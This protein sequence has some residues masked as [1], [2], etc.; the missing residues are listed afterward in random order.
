MP[1]TVMSLSAI[2]ASISAQFF[3]SWQSNKKSKEL[4]ARQREF[5]RAAQEKDFVRMRR[6]QQE[7]EQLA[8]DL[9]NEVHQQ[10]LKDIESNY[11][12]IIEDFAKQF[13]IKLWPLKVLP[14]VM[15][16]E[17][18][19]SIINGTKSVALHCI[20]TPSN[21]NQFNRAVYQD[22]DLRLESLC[23][24]H[25]NAQS[26]HPIVYYG[27]SWRKSELDLD[28]I[29]LLHTQLKNIPT[30]I[31]TPYFSPNLYFKI[32]LWGMGKYY[33]FNI[34][35]PNDKFSYEYKKGMEY[36]PKNEIPVDDLYNSTIDE[37]VPYLE[38]LIGFILDQ[39]YWSFYGIAPMFPSLFKSLDDYR[40]TGLLNNFKDDYI[41]I[42]S[43]EL[44]Q[45]GITYSHNKE[46]ILSLY[47]GIYSIL[48]QKERNVFAK[49]MLSKLASQRGI[50]NLNDHTNLIKC[51]NIKDIEFLQ[52]LRNVIPLKE[53]KNNLLLIINDLNARIPCSYIHLENITFSEIMEYA[54]RLLYDY[55]ELS[56]K[57]EIKKSNIMIALCDI[58][59]GEFIYDSDNPKCIIILYKNL[60]VN[61]RIRI[62]SP[63]IMLSYEDFNTLYNK[64]NKV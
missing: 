6:I 52:K 50:L 1:L 11:D 43:Q 59:T 27:D 22:I 20:L 37:M 23:N 12:E 5:Q 38:S 56:I 62:K 25:W 31:I 13:T 36:F 19:G 61:D 64:I 29:E 40:E 39:Y 45:N 51:L 41:K 46:Y 32:K 28:D 10:R 17:S 47:E 54:N 34:N 3:N 30:V 48:T 35:I 53:V 26:T 2:A 60:L 42:L 24:H 58:N 15:R 8:L 33:N 44:T 21:C 18:F 63:S 9:E 55:R 7:A 4:I 16:G 57:I 14:F 49:K